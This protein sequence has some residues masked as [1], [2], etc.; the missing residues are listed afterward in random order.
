MEEL[1]ERCAGLDVHKKTVVA[2]IMIGF[3]KKVKK[4]IRTFETMTEDLRHM[5]RW[6]QENGV[7][8]AA[9]ESTGVYW[10][11][12]FNILEGEYSIN[13]ILVNARH[14]KNVPG[15][16][17]DTKDSEWLCKPLKNGLL[18]KS[19]VPKEEFRH[20]RN[21]DRHRKAVLRDLTGAKN[22]IIKNLEMHNIKLASV[23]SSVHGANGRRI[24]KEIAQGETN[25]NKLILLI[26][27]QLKTPKS[28]ILRALTGTMQ[29][30]HF[31]S[32]KRLIDHVEYL[33]ALVAD[34]EKEIKDF[35]EKHFACEAKLIKEIP[36]I[37]DNIAATVIAEI[38]TN[39]DQ[40]HSEKHLASWVGLAPGNNES[41]G[42]KKNCAI[43]EGN[44]HLK[45]TLV[46]GA[47]SGIRSK[48]TF[49]GAVFKRLRVKLG[50][51]KAV[52]AISR[53]MIVCIY[54]VLKKKI[55]YK[56]LGADYV[57][58]KALVQ[59]AVYYRKKLAEL[60]GVL[61]HAA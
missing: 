43:S 51:K 20:L 34:I 58:K 38:G 4:E 10:R 18:S 50:A 40:F 49:W 16:K 17:T 24:V 14:I 36:G 41:A 60:E 8:N 26:D 13:I 45:T 53:K 2:C 28:E 22:R 3:G 30:H 48:V 21:L 54:W 32:F 25:P 23:L 47:W 15:K 1:L 27:R 37:S 61:T 11:P 29:E 56:E 44:K 33:E 9:I 55:S 52:I 35:V 6:L 42:K 57:D 12:V 31:K 46:Q 7:L 39:M 5:A 59:K 19:F